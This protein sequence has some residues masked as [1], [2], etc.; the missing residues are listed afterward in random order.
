[1]RSPIQEP[2]F[3]IGQVFPT[4]PLA[5]RWPPM[6]RAANR[7]GRGK[8]STVLLFASEQSNF[9]RQPAERN[10]GG[11]CVLSESR[12][13]SIRRILKNGHF[14]TVI[15]ETRLVRC[16]IHA[17]SLPLNSSIHGFRSEFRLARADGIWRNFKLRRKTGASIAAIR[18]DDGA[19]RRIK[20]RRGCHD[21][22]SG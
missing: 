21:R 1:M 17:D 22:S 6:L 16:F 14:R 3:P 2:P 5:T 12:I 20:C 10:L 8:R 13:A 11:S 4:L 9:R 19:F 18:I 7:I 15:S